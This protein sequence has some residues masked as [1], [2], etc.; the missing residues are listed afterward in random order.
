MSHYIRFLIVTPAEVL[1]FLPEDGWSQQQMYF[2]KIINMESTRYQVFKRNRKCVFC[3]VEGVFMA[4]EQDQGSSKRAQSPHFNLYTIDNR[5]MTQDHIIPLSKGGKDNL[6]NLQTA[7]LKCNNKKGNKL[8][9]KP[10]L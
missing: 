5:L 9:W 8:L 3:G 7:C 6:N 2:G 1:D 10:K 4:L